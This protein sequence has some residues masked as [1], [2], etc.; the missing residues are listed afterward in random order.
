MVQSALGCQ[1]MFARQLC[2]NQAWTRV[3]PCLSRFLPLHTPLPLLSLCMCTWRREI[4]RRLLCLVQP[5][6]FGLRPFLAQ[7]LTALFYGVPTGDIHSGCEKALS[8]LCLEPYFQRSCGSSISG[9][10]N[11]VDDYPESIMNMGFSEAG[12][13]VSTMQGTQNLP[14]SLG[15]GRSL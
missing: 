15:G 5:T 8:Q 1:A 12:R 9:K 11:G 3:F 4:N 6:L 2:R 7:G 13:G 10:F 14:L